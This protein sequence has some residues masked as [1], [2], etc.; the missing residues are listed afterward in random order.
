TLAVLAGLLAAAL[1]WPQGDS[2]AALFVAFLVVG[3][4][5]RLIRRNVDV[6]MDRAPADATEA[7]RR[8][9]REQVPEVAL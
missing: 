6:L 3:A 8:A 1:G 4:A 5:T 2:V 7:A 9:I